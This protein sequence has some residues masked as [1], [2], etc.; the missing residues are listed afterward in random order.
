[1]ARHPVQKRHKVLP[2]RKPTPYDRVQ[3][4]LDDLKDVIHRLYIVEDKNL[5]DVIAFIQTNH[6]VVQS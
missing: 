2:K 5:K 6:G 3:S 1:M 4:P